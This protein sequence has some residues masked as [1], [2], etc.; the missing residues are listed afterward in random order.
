MIPGSDYGTWRWRDWEET[1]FVCYILR[2]PSL[3]L[4]LG[5]PFPYRILGERGEVVNVQFF[6]EVRPVRMHGFDAHSKKAGDFFHGP[7]FGKELSDLTLA[8][9]PPCE[10]EVGNVGAPD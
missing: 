8:S 3:L 5:Q 4:K 2:T 1:E 10:H 9:R 6:H 7:A